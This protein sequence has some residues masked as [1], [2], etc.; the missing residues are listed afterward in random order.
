VRKNKSGHVGCGQAK[1]Q[2]SKRSPHPAFPQNAPRIL[3][4]DALATLNRSFEQVLS[5]FHRLEGLRL[6]PHRW[7]RKFLQT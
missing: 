6:F 3:I 2:K 4:Y 7:Q 1:K 5:D